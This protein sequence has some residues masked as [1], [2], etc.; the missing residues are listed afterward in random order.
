MVI[1]V[2]IAVTIKSE[3]IGVQ[4]LAFIP[5]FSV[6]TSIIGWTRYTPRVSGESTIRHFL[7][8]SFTDILTFL[9]NKNIADDIMNNVILYGVFMEISYCP[10][11]SEN[12]E[13]TI[14]VT[15]T[16]TIANT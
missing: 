10:L 15:G 11:F 1:A 5:I 2:T 4:M 8:F 13:S 3:I 16:S 9:I 7:T 14:P 12:A 6:K